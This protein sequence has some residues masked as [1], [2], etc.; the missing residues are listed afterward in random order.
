MERGRAGVLRE[1]RDGGGEGPEGEERTKTGGER[2]RLRRGDRLKTAHELG[3]RKGS[4][5]YQASSKERGLTKGRGSL[6]F[7][8]G[9]EKKG[10][11]RENGNRRLG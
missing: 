3:K 10:L 5:V 2:G 7:G 8:S 4:P 9:L 6:V 1:A 11:G